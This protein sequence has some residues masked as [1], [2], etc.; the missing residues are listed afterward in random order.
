MDLVCVT[1]AGTELFKRMDNVTTVITLIR[2][3]K[4]LDRS[5]M[6]Q[7][8]T[9]EI[10]PEKVRSGIISE[11]D[12]AREWIAKHT[13]R[14]EPTQYLKK[15]LY[16]PLSWGDRRFGYLHTKYHTSVNSML[17]Q[18][19]W[20]IGFKV[21]PEILYKEMLSLGHEFT[22]V[23]NWDTTVCTTIEFENRIPF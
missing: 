9:I 19:V 8:K 23:W 20:A 15:T 3:F 22:N 11:N 5:S 21:D 17:D 16:R 10:T 18:I 6:M 13:R 1:N 12:I 2:M 4:G 7:S 14:T